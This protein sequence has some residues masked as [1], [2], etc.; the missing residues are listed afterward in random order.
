MCERCPYPARAPW[1]FTGAMAGSETP[2]YHPLRSS[3]RTGR[4]AHT[5]SQPSPACQHDRSQARTRAPRRSM[6]FQYCEKKIS[7][8]RIFGQLHGLQGHS[9]HCLHGNGTLWWSGTG[10]AAGGPPIEEK[11]T[12]GAAQPAPMAPWTDGVLGFVWFERVCVWWLLHCSLRVGS[13]LPLRVP[14]WHVH[15][16]GV[17]LSRC[18]IKK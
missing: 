3:T 12:A 10:A 6:F 17:V 1:L 8:R 2:I 15:V 5:P 11:C 16:S 14:K 13:R 4:C 9:G 18:L 7:Q